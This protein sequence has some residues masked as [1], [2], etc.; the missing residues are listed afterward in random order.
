MCSESEDGDIYYFNFRTKE[1]SWEHPCDS[2]YKELLE[3]EREKIRANSGP[4]R[5]AEMGQKGLVRKG[6]IGQPCSAPTYV[7]VSSCSETQVRIHV[8]ICTYVCMYILL[9][10]CVQLFMGG[11]QTHVCTWICLPML[12]HV[13]VYLWTVNGTFGPCRVVCLY[14]LH[15]AYA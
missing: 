13:Y 6:C 8:C 7:P 9:C 3:R 14:T 4:S 5:K 1:S 12:A 15:L 11:M 10:V 2:F